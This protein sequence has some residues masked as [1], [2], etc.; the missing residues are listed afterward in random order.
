MEVYIV[1]NQVRLAVLQQFEF[2][3]ETASIA[4]TPEHELLNGV[5]VVQHA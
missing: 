4:P 3:S 1:K 5:K 2:G